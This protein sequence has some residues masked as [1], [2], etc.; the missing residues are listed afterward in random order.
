MSTF[1]FFAST[2]GFAVLLLAVLYT[3]AYLVLDGPMIPVW[4]MTIPALI[5]GLTATAAID[6]P[7]ERA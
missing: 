3:P 2:V 1:K 4:W 7:L 5:F 6:K